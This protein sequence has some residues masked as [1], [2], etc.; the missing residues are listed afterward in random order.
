MVRNVVFGGW[1]LLSLLGVSEFWRMGKVILKSSVESLTQ[2]RREAES[3]EKVQKSDGKEKHDKKN[4]GNL[5]HPI[6]ENKYMLKQWDNLCDL[7]LS[8]PLREI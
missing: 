3:A 6:G 1:Q 8:A 7:C 5:F 4:L 2:R